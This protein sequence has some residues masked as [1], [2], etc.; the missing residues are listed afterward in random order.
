MHG[1]M[2]AVQSP[3]FLYFRNARSPCNPQVCRTR[4]NTADV[5][6]ANFCLKEAIQLEDVEQE[7]GADE[8]GMAPC[9]HLKA[10]D[11]GSA[12]ILGGV[13]GLLP[14]IP[15]CVHSRLERAWTST[16][17]ARAAIK[18]PLATADFWEFEVLWCAAFAYR[19]C[20]HKCLKF[21]SDATF[22]LATCSPFRRPRTCLF[23]CVWKPLLSHNLFARHM[24]DTHR[25]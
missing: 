14:I 17:W 22:L 23:A 10:I 19:F 21:C 18:R 9:S 2:W 5:K 4:P 12:Q 1:W 25:T 8:H 24:L 3:A 16:A 7:R 6:P 20:S 15:E 11:F 13:L